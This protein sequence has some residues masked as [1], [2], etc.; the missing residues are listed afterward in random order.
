[1]PQHD[2]HAA[3]QL[4]AELVDGNRCCD[5]VES[6]AAATGVD[7]DSLWI[8]VLDGPAAHRVA[9]A[10]DTPPSVLCVAARS[11]DDRTRRAAA[12]NTRT[13]PDALAELAEHDDQVTRA[14]VAAN[15]STPAASLDTLAEDQDPTVRASA[16]SNAFLARA[17]LAKLAGDEWAQVRAAVACHDNTPADALAGLAEDRDIDVIGRL[18]ANASTPPAALRT[19]HRRWTSGAFHQTALPERLAQNPN[20]PADVLDTL[21]GSPDL[22]STKVRAQ[23]AV[24]P[25][26]SSAARSHLVAELHQ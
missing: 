12:S 11:G 13:P 10:T 26:T 16:A 3:A 2:V 15:A 4:V 18:A 6:A 25:N 14:H 1:M 23:I 7:L 20:T 8:A 19:L 21:A 22:F 17:A 5:A 24:H 9:A